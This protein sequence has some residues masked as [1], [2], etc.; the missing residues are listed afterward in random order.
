MAPITAMVYITDR[1]NS[2]N[3]I[4]K[5]CIYIFNP[6]TLG[7]ME[8]SLKCCVGVVR[9]SL[10]NSSSAGEEKP[11]FIPPRNVARHV[12]SEH[13]ATAHIRSLFDGDKVKELLPSS[14]FCVKSAALD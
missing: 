9:F 11:I 7:N 5:F 3:H 8:S 2:Y 13:L 6:N 1:K 10:V 14:K 12:M 4:T